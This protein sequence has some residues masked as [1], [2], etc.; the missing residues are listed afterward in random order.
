MIDLFKDRY[1]LDLY[2]LRDALLGRV[3]GWEPYDLGGAAV[4]RH[5]YRNPIPM[6]SRL[7]GVDAQGA[8]V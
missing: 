3:A 2:D 1:T 8:M 5:L 6:L 4:P 7:P